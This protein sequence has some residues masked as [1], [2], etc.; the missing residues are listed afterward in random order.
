MNA[1]RTILVSLLATPFTAHATS[2]NF[3]DLEEYLKSARVIA[4]VEVISNVPERIVPS[5]DVA[6]GATVT[7]RVVESFRGKTTGGIIR[8]ESEGMTVG[9]QYV[10]ALGPYHPNAIDGNSVVVNLGG[11]SADQAEEMTLACKK[12]L[13]A[14]SSWWRVTSEI[15]AS[16]WVS[17]GYKINLPER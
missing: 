3:E 10:V 17:W 4:H 14:M 7:A 13:P 16:R 2:Y 9:G 12:R 8:F 5:V 11:M 1:L 6:C 15:V